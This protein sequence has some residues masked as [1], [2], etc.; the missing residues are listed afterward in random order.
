MHFHT[1]AF[2]YFDDFTIPNMTF[3]FKERRTWLRPLNSQ[4]RDLSR[5]ALLCYAKE[6]LE[7]AIL[8]RRLGTVSL[9]GLMLIISF[10]TQTEGLHVTS[11]LNAGFVTVLNVS[12]VPLVPD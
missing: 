1:A 2:P 7:T 9:V 8:P 4:R 12:L 11:V 3:L 6:R 10:Y 5:V